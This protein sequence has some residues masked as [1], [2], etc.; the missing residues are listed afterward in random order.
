MRNIYK[1]IFILLSFG[2]QAQL[3][4]AHWYFGQNAGLDFSSGS[5]VAVT[6]GQI[7]TVEGSTTYSDNDGNL[8][9]YTDGQTVYNRNHSI[10][11]GGTGL[12]GHESSTQSA[13]IIPKPDSPDIYYIFTIW[14]SNG[15]RYNVVDMSQD[16]GNGAVIEKNTFLMSLTGMGGSEKLTAAT[17]AGC[18]GYW[19]LTHFIGSFYAFSVTS[20]GVSLQPVI[21]TIGIQSYFPIQGAGH[22]KLSPNGKKLAVAHRDF[23][24]NVGGLGL[25]DF[26]NSSGTV[27]NEQLIYTPN[28]ANK[29]RYY[30]VEFSPD[31]NVLYATCEAD[32]TSG[33]KNLL[34]QYDLTNI[35]IVNSRYIIDSWDG[36][37]SGALQ[38][39]LNNK[40]YHV[41]WSE[42]LA[43]INNPNEVYNN[44]TGAHPDYVIN[45]VYLAGRS[46]THGLPPFI[47]SL[48]Y[49][50]I[51]IN[52][53]NNL[54]E[55][56]KQELNFTYCHNG[57]EIDSIL[58]DFGDGTTSSLENP[59][60]TYEPGTYTLKLQ[61]TIGGIPYT[62]EEII[63]IH[64]LPVAF[65]AELEE[66]LDFSGNAEFDLTES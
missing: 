47:T 19:V 15:L 60:H 59:V 50:G 30:G 48:F 41:R 13:I 45:G 42:Y 14:N 10:M 46:S 64:P 63:T 58:W 33:T 52:G 29:R 20:A 62:T 51:M 16:G 24:N 11:V 21:S 49:A 39:G 66:C 35:S 1:I 23:Y 37:V 38:L 9:F 4:T 6:D 31:N 7:N 18:S 36:V 3:Q 28:Q 55:Y 34:E 22:I 40:I 27:S 8:I 25:Y 44:G 43:V 53:I 17:I 12:M 54:G 57:G 65:D 5:P 2:L 32:N 61:L 56:C 26:D